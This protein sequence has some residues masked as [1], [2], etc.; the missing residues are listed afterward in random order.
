[1]PQQRSHLLELRSSTVKQISKH[2]R[3]LVSREYFM[4]LRVQSALLPLLPPPHPR[5]PVT[6]FLTNPQLYWTGLQPPPSLPRALLPG[7]S[8]GDLRGTREPSQMDQSHFSENLA[9]GVKVPCWA[10]AWSPDWKRRSG[11]RQ[12]AT[13]APLRSAPWTCSSWSAEPRPRGGDAGE[14]GQSLCP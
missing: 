8:S 5:T 13:V 10:R 12:E 2:F 11:R 9:W 3:K 14:R 6:R 7:H 4:A 1:M